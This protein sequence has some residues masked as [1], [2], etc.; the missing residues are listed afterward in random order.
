MGHPREK[1]VPPASAALGDG[2]TKLQATAGLTRIVSAEVRDPVVDSERT[3][4]NR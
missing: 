1:Q 4:L 3:G 2:M